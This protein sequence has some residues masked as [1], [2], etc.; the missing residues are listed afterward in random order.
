MEGL[1][2]EGPK[3]CRQQD[4]LSE[5]AGLPTP[6]LVTPASR[7]TRELQRFLLNDSL[8]PSVSGY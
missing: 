6:H 3:E 7:D 1:E 4:S 2:K 5:G 8:G